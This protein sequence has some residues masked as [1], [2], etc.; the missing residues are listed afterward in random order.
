[1]AVLENEYL[2]SA[3]VAFGNVGRPLAALR[4]RS[5]AKGN[6]PCTPRTRYYFRMLLSL[7]E[8]EVILSRVWMSMSLEIA[9]EL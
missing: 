7:M 2:V 6:A 4:H 9:L 8:L 1:M 3:H 5:K